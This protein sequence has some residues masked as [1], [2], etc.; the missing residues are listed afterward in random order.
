MLSFSLLSDINECAING[1]NNCHKHANCSNDVGSFS[2][3]CMNGFTGNGTFCEGELSSDVLLRCRLVIA[4]CCYFLI[5]GSELCFVFS[6]IAAKLFFL[7]KNLSMGNIL[8]FF[9]PL[10]KL[11]R[12]WCLINGNFMFR[13]RLGTALICSLLLGNS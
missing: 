13:L 11:Q 9:A 6:C 5:F 1:T 7:C 4:C 8:M 12:R 3:S 10:T 2:C